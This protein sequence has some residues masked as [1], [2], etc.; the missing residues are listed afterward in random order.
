MPGAR[1]AERDGY[2]PSPADLAQ[3]CPRRAAQ[4]RRSTTAAVFR[5]RLPSRDS[6]VRREG[7]DR[8]RRRW[9]GP[10]ERPSQAY[11]QTPRR[12]NR[13]SP[14]HFDQGGSKWSFRLGGTTGRLAGSCVKRKERATPEK[15][16]R[17]GH[18]LAPRPGES[19]RHAPRDVP[20]ARHAECD[21]YFPSPTNLFSPFS[22]GAAG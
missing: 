2:F 19:S 17:M 16:P 9:R 11:G 22:R 1:Q 3:E 4:R 14:P 21:G 7:R 6:Q 15:G 5:R 10:G 8:R 20:G 18:E 12:S 13:Q